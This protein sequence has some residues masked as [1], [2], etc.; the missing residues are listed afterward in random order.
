MKLLYE[1]IIW[2]Y[3]MKLLYEIIIVNYYIIKY[4]YIFCSI[5]RLLMRWFSCG[6]IGP[7][8]RARKVGRPRWR[9]AATLTNL[10]RVRWLFHPTVRT[11]LV[12]DVISTFYGPPNRCAPS[13]ALKISS[14][15]LIPSKLDS[16][17]QNEITFFELDC[18]PLSSPP[19]S[20]KRPVLPTEWWRA[21]AL[22][23]SRTFTTWHRNIASCLKICR[24]LRK[25]SAP[26]RSH[27]SF[28]Y[29][30][31]PAADAVSQSATNN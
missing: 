22:L 24:N 9:Y 20:I 30:V 6:H 3:Y 12:M 13:A 2:N 4:L 14:E 15:I 19:P 5:K 10:D 17:H 11:A 27:S 23:A 21:N 29:S 16:N 18:S 31:H 8:N 1:T 7:Q 25:P 28:R 26:L